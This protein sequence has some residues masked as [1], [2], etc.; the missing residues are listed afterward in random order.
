MKE[1]V[2]REALSQRMRDDAEFQRIVM[3]AREKGKYL[4]YYSQSADELGGVR[5]QDGRIEGENRVGKII[6]ELAEF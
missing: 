1:N 2:L 4:L 6:M 5:K 3:A